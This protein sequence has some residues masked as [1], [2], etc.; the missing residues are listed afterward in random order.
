MPD[1]TRSTSSPANTDVQALRQSRAPVCLQLGAKLTNGRGAGADPQIGRQAALE[2]TDR[3]IG[4]LD[5]ADM[6]FVT[7]GLGGGTGTGAAPVIANLASELGALTV[8]VVTKP[9]AF[10]GRHR[11]RQA[12]VG[13]AELRERVDTAVVIPN[14]RLLTAIDQSTSVVDAFGC[15]GNILQQA[16]HG[17]ADLLLVPG[18]INLDFADVMAVMSRMGLAFM[19]TGEGAG[20]SRATQAVRQAVS[21]PLLEG[22][23]IDGARGVIVNVTGGP[24]LTMAEVS[25]AT[26][27]VYDAADDDANIIF[28]ATVMPEMEGRVKITV[29]ATGFGV[30]ATDEQGAWSAPT[31]VDLKAYTQLQESQSAVE[32]AAPTAGDATIDAQPMADAQEQAGEGV[33]EIDAPLEAA[34]R[35]NE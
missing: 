34:R 10:E 22:A 30:G 13:I 5:G 21:S 28:G 26:S 4:V 27:V 23:S 20:E 11:V 12:E 14:D 31:P 29:V 1:S 15:A 25:E 9:F 6:V 16:I 35:A 17:I 19:G 8:A 33:L 3:I 24:D 2:D 18:L 7:A 32:A